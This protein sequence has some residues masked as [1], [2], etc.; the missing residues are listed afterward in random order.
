MIKSEQDTSLNRLREISGRITE[1]KDSID[2]PYY[3]HSA[4]ICHPQM[5]YLQKPTEKE[6][7]KCLNNVSPPKPKK[8]FIGRVWNYYISRLMTKPFRRSMPYIIRH[9]YNGTEGNTILDL[10]V[11]LIYK[12]NKAIDL[13]ISVPKP[14]KMG[15]PSDC[16]HNYKNKKILKETYSDKTEYDYVDKKVLSYINKLDDKL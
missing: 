15:V 12:N 14:K 5:T 6:C 7:E 10:Y 11:G 1:L 4:D 8:R 9:F 3:P 2:Y 13:K 16:I